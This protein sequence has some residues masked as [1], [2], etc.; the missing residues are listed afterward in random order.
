MKIQ[1]LLT[2]F[3]ALVLQSLPAAA[4]TIDGTVLAVDRKAKTLVLTDRTAWALDT[5]QSTLPDGLKAGDRIEIDYDSDE[6]GVSAIRNISILPM[7]MAKSGA[8]DSAIGTVLV[9][10]RKANI[11]VF[12]DRTVWALE[13]MNSAMPAALKAGDRVQIEY[14]SDEEGVSAINSISI[15]PR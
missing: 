1:L 9:Y 10:D 15:L 5:I 11:L 7:A 6:E 13:V 8:S 12:T 3:S 2:L 14:E 4:D